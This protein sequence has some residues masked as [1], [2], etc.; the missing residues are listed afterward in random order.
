VTA[1]AQE[2]LETRRQALVSKIALQRLELRGNVADLRARAPVS[3]VVQLLRAAQVAIACWNVG[4][5]A[6]RVA[7]AAFRGRRA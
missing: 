1:M 7:A 4:G 6:W 3:G 5:L 2:N